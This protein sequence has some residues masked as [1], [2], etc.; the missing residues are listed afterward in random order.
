MANMIARTPTVG[1]LER[2]AEVAQIAFGSLSL[3]H[4]VESFHKVNDMFGREFTIVVEVDGQIVS[5]L[6]CCPA[7][8]YVAECRVTHS[9]VGGVATLP[10]YRKLGCAGVMMAE[11]VKRLRKSGIATSSLWPFSYDYYRKFG[12]EVGAEVRKYGAPGSV[13]AALGNAGNARAATKEDFG[14]IMDCYNTLAPTL[15]C[16][17]ERSKEWWHRMSCVPE[18]L[19]MVTESGRG[20]V[21]HMNGKSIDGYAVY[22]VAVKDESRWI[23]VKEM[24]SDSPGARMDMLALLATID[25]ELTINFHSPVEDS[26]MQELPNPRLVSCAVAPSFQFRVIDPELAMKSLTADEEVS[27][28]FTL[29]LSDPVFKHGFEFGVDVDEGEVSLCKPERKNR[30]DMDV[31]TLARLYSGYLSPLEAY[32]LGKV[33]A[34]DVTPV[35][36]ACE[37][38]P[39]LQ[40]YRSWLEPG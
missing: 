23:E 40:P 26:F 7:P 30:L 28:R 38:F 31:Q 29:S 27:G 13:Y 16:L 35:L 20:A 39:Q 9:S 5:T 15:N 1:E 6:L 10:D 18:D 33:R 8:I 19:S 2:A 34:D 14:A 17:T 37:T 12:W 21:V 25:P 36:L 32:Y 3:E 24:F 11:T 4:W 22:D